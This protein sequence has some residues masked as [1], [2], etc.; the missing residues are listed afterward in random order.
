MLL[1]WSKLH[2]QSKTYKGTVIMKVK[3]TL[4][5]LACSM[6]LACGGSGGG[7]SAS[8]PD[9]DANG[10][11]SGLTS[12]SGFT[13]ETISLLNDGALIAINLDFDEFYKGTYSIDGDRISAS[14]RGYELNG[15]FGGTG[16]LSGIVTSKG[17]LKATVESSS[18]GTSDVDLVYETQVYERS[19]SLAD[20]AGSWAGSIPGLTFAITID[21]SGR[22]V[23]SGSDGCIVSG[24]L[25]IPKADRNM[26]AGNISVSGSACTVSG[27]YDGLGLLTD[28]ATTNDVLVFGYANDN[29]G[30][31]YAA[32][33]N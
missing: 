13:S 8:V 2:N 25:R 31:A 28:N 19:I 27:N 21:A 23:A 14:I 26:I 22:L 7:N 32:T 5:G 30:F 20:L 11:W 24:D 12:I 3:T 4:V 17:A 15:P 18:G 9:E 29:Y 10:I 16:T 1:K 6:L 33:R